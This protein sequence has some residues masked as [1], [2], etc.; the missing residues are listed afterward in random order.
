MKKKITIIFYAKCKWQR[1]EK[2]L[3]NK[4]TCAHTQTAAA[5]KMNKI[6]LFLLIWNH[7]NY[8]QIMRKKTKKKKKK[9][10]TESI[11]ILDENLRQKIGC[12]V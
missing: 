2:I 12:I 3:I 5:E 4:H 6:S 8:S 9:I 7:Q 10:I 11:K 1:N